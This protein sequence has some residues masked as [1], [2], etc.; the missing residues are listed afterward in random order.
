[1]G[2]FKVVKVSKAIKVIKVTKVFSDLK[3]FYTSRSCL[4]SQRKMRPGKV[5]VNE[6]L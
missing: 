1:M 6:M 2:H 3:S 5:R 4:R